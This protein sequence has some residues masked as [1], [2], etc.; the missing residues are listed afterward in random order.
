LKKLDRISRELERATVP[1]T[2][3]EQQERAAIAEH[4]ALDNQ[5]TRLRL[6][7]QEANLQDQ[8]S[9]FQHEGLDLKHQVRHLLISS[10]NQFL[11]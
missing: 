10:V 4:T 6:V 7:S 5:L 11:D 2:E 9:S 8:L 3:I 1:L